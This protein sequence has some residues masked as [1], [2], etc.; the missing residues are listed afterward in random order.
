MG[1][2]RCEGTL[3]STKENKEA[4]SSTCTLEAACAAGTILEA[5]ASVFD[6]NKNLLVPLGGMQGIMPFY[7]CAM[8]LREGTAR[9]ISVISRVGK[10]VC[11]VVTGFRTDAR[12]A[13]CAL[14]SR[15]AVQ[16]ACFDEYLT[17]LVPGDVIDCA[18]THVEPFGAFAD[19]G[20]GISAL[21]P[22]DYISVS[23]IRHPSQRVKP[24]MRLRCVVR[25]VDDNGRL[26]LTHKEL[27][28]SWEQNAALFE[29]GETVTGT[30]RSVESY[31]V[32]VELTPNLA[33]LAEPCD[34]AREGLCAS[35][36]IKSILPD[37]MKLKLVIVDCF[38]PEN[39][40]PPPFHY[41][42]TGAHMNSF[43]YS[44]PAC[45]KRIETF[46]E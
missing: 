37:R 27:L 40:A 25:A 4:L 35:V 15:R 26:L 22:I 16:Q 14:L 38:E 11:F 6:K 23:R 20:C 12:G 45:S 5:R 21:L 2:Y 7:E 29:A 33:G 10:P 32:F 9:E 18:V 8:G 17:R 34:S 42:F 44:P 1:N 36:Y 31:G 24:G 43:L 41:F 46:F 19:V 3:F 30:V 13:R 39:P 28:G